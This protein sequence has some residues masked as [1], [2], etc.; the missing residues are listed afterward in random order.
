MSEAEVF[1]HVELDG[2]TRLVGQLYV[3]A[4]RAKER[5]AFRYAAEWLEAPE[6]FELEPALE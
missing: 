1:V 4:T 5:A 6:R 3:V 2:V